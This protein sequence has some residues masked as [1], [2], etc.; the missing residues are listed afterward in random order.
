VLEV[1]N[2]VCGYG[3]EIVLNQ[4]S[5]CINQGE[6]LCILGANGIGKTTLFK[7]VQGHIRLLSGEIFLQG[8]KLNNYSDKG[9][10][11]QIA[12]VPQAHVPPFPFK[13]IDV[14]VMGRV[15][16]IGTFSQPSQKDRKIAQEAL[17]RVN[18]HQ[19]QDKIY[20]LISG[21][22]RQLVL[23]ARAIAQE[24][25][26]LILDEPTANLDYGNQARIL[27]QI[28]RLADMGYS[29][30]YTTHNPEHA[31]SCSDQVLA[32]LNKDEHVIGNADQ[33]ITNKLLKKIYR[34]D[35]VVQTIRMD[36]RTVRK[37]II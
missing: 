28:R 8:I 6:I 12:Y 7:S 29:V 20:T 4:L 22:E 5:F 36:N 9:R 31:F 18:I 3:K 34:I 30:I 24:A 16:H 32:I 37:C 15:A 21:G 11:K 17:K 27:Q 25:N 23:I 33:V 35:A 10:A 13:V 19:L 14:V 1:K 26:I 2:A